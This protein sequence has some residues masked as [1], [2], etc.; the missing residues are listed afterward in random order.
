MLNINLKKFGLKESLEEV[1]LF[2][3]ILEFVEGN[4]LEVY[5]KFILDIVIGYKI[6]FIRWDEIDVS[7]YFID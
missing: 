7:W 1:I 6:L 3:N 5:E 2:F 4:I